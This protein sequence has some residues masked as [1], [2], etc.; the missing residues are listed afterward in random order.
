TLERVALTNNSA[1]A[2][3]GALDLAFG[4]TLVLRGSLLAGNRAETLN[5]GAIHGGSSLLIIESSFHTN[6]AG[7]RGGAIHHDAGLLTMSNCT[8]SGNVANDHGGGISLE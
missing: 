2:N 5:G 1:S 7:L 3:G 4:T 6:R 8:V